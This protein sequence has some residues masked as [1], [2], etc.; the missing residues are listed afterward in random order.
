MNL[1]TIQK[2]ISLLFSVG[3]IV[4]GVGY[5]YGQFK[6]GGR[7]VD[8]D[9]QKAQDGALKTNT[10]TLEL[11]TKNI[12]ALQQSKVSQDKQIES[13]RTEIQELKKSIEEKDKKLT[14]YISIMQ[15]KDPKLEQAAIAMITFIS[16]SELFMDGIN[17][18]VEEM[19]SN[20][21]KL[22]GAMQHTV[23]K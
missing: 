19:L 5:A 1:E 3:L 14:E 16:K 12:E 22:V 8:S 20:T 17:R 7:T 2:I 21:N 11:L 10:E 18:K 13:L 15:G 6:K 9:N 23:I 4:A